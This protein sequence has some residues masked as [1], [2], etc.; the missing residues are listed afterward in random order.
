MC[1]RSAQDKLRLGALVL[2][3]FL[4]TTCI[5][6]YSV[7]VS[8]LG[9]VTSIPEASHNRTE[10]RSWHFKPCLHPWFS[11]AVSFF[12]ATLLSP[13]ITYLPALD[14]NLIRNRPRLA[15]DPTNQALV[16]HESPR[17]GITLQSHLL[18]G[19]FQHKSVWVPSLKF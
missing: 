9:S 8:G 14:L 10:E 5:L 3:A 17:F 12:P 6:E 7:A 11:E 15:L 4:S 19:K 16:L 13:L 18:G 1:G 2:W